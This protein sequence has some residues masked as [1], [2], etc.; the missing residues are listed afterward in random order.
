M[1][2]DVV[3]IGGGIAGLYSAYN[4]MKM[5]PS[6]SFLVLEKY[7][8]K[9]LGGRMNNEIFYNTL[10]VTGA[11][12]IRKKK[13][14]L[15]LNL[16]HQLD[17]P[18]RQSK[19]DPHYANTFDPVNVEKIMKFLRSKYEE[20]TSKNKNMPALTFKQ[21]AE[22][23]L[24][25]EIYNR[26]ITTIGY[27]DYENEDVN[28]TLYHYEMEDNICC[29]DVINI[30]WNQ[31]VLKL[32][33]EIG[34]KNI[35]T[36]SEVIKVQKLE[37]NPCNFFIETKKGV[38]Y[39]CNKVIVATTIDGLRKLMPGG[40]NPNNIYQ[41]IEGQPFLRLYGKFSKKSIPI[42]EQYVPN[43][44]IVPGPLQKIIPINIKS[45]IYMISYSDNKNALLLKDH[46]DNTSENREY[47][48]RLIETSLDI[49]EG[50]L[51]LNA[52]S[53][54][55]WPI[56]THYFKPLQKSV[57]VNR[58]EFLYKA[59]HPEKGIIVVGEVVSRNQGWSEGALESVKYAL[60]KKW[61]TEPC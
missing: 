39:T 16:I 38:S 49:P 60:T 15:L 53:D 26:F 21:F 22:H 56:G 57:Y 42:I 37:N 27:T 47:F 30:Y 35:K 50:T 17:I 3:I 11:G 8:K 46:L 12:V 5:S 18:T 41:Q 20:N 29:W 13:D 14:K 24:G 4:I 55:Y 34:L 40:Q 52:I 54:Y 44:T 7:K 43:Y 1:Y 59:Q 31:L 51:H 33:N 32:C 28:E 45:G 9:W 61:L 36:S 48:C 25:K 19:F 58:E 23:I 10:V 2:Y 6:T